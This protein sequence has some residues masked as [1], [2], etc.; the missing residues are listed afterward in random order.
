[1]RATVSLLD[2]PTAVSAA[3]RFV[4]LIEDTCAQLFVAGSLRR[5]L[6]RVGD[7]EFVAVPATEALAHPDLE[8][9]VEDGTERVAERLDL[10]N[11][12]MGALLADGAVTQRLDVHG[13]PRWGPTLKYLWFDGVRVDLF[14]P[15]AERLGWILLLRT[16]PA[17]FSRQ[18]V[19]PRGKKTRD[20]RPGLL[21]PHI[22]S[23]DG[24]LTERASAYRLQTPTERDVFELFDLRYLEPWERT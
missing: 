23:R 12:R 19:V 16:G 6:A 9:F 14:A 5:R 20:G 11:L 10:L 21:P 18:L 24:W 15:C 8:M 1:M 4:G 7:I 13:V 2:R 3:K 22:Q 17:A